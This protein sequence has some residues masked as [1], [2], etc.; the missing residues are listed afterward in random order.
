[1][2]TLKKYLRVYQQFFVSNLSV[3]MSFRF[4]FCMVFLVEI[5]WLLILLASAAVLYGNVQSFNGWSANHF[6]FF[7]TIVAMYDQLF[8]GLFAKNFWTF[9]ET[10]RLGTMD[11]ILTKPVSSLFSVFMRYQRVSGI[12]AA[13]LT[14]MAAVYFASRIEA[15]DPS[16]NLLTWQNFLGLGCLFFMGMILR[17]GMEIVIGTFM[18]IT[19]EGEA[20]NIF[21]L[22]MQAFAKYPDF[23]Y[24][25]FSKVFLY[26]I[27]PLCMVSTLP[28]AW[29]FGKASESWTEAIL[30][31]FAG[32]LLVWTIVFFVWRW[33]INRYESASS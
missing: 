13:A 12:F 6:Y 30:L 9:S 1:V 5:C 29:F 28:P 33:G 20:I 24:R 10:L 8:L 7:C 11:F 27:F 14:S 25:G 2:R 16:L 22:N 3:E 31:L 17:V 4:S 23:I 26:Y 32:A 21:R 19:V 18:F 15:A